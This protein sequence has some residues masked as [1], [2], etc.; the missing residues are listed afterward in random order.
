MPSPMDDG[1]R[2]ERPYDELLARV[3]QRG[4]RIR[5]R[6]QA[7]VAGSTA[8]VLALL[9]ATPLALGNGE[10]DRRVETVAGPGGDEP[11]TS[12]P[13]TGGDGVTTTTVVA[14]PD[15]TPDTT[16]TS[17]PRASTTVPRH[18]TVT[19]T[20]GT[21]PVTTVPPPDPCAPRAGRGRIALVRSNALHVVNPDG[22]CLERRAPE[23]AFDQD[24]AWSPDGSKLAFARAANI[25]VMDADGGNVRQLTTSGADR[26]PAWS[27]DGRR[28][29]FV[30]QDGS[31]IWVMS[32]DGSGPSVLYDPPDAIPLEVSWS[33]DGTRLAF[34]G[35]S[36]GIWVVGADGA[37]PVKVNAGGNSPAW[38]PDGRIAF[39]AASGSDVSALFLMDAR[40]D[41][42]VPLGFGT[43][44]NDARPAWSADGGSLAFESYRDGEWAVYA[45]AVGIW[46]PARVAPG[47]YAA[48]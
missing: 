43:S 42:M 38:G 37:S 18:P 48:W 17:G 44:Q 31:G 6:R 8:L 41:G 16:P 21:V 33:P 7:L 10:A 13:T 19:T 1:P 40:F 15:S 47:I 46:K 20:P 4:A 9:I 36:P 2:P 23:G 11:N 27:P 39:A 14:G 34:S 26:G 45:M 3:V 32:A 12:T 35:T 22:S 29:A 30:R 25:T 28:I 24:P 5:R